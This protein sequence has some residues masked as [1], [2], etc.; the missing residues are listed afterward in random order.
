MKKYNKPEI[1][2][3]II[4]ATDV[5]TTSIVIDIDGGT[6]EFPEAWAGISTTSW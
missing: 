1:T 3:I 6:T 2:E 4:E 5:I